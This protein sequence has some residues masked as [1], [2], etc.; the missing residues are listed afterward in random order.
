MSKEYDFFLENLNLLMRSALPV[1]EAI[2]TLKEEIK[3]RKMLRAIAIIENEI[4]GGSKMSTALGKSGLLSERYIALLRLGEETGELQKQLALVVEEQKKEKALQSK[5]RGAL[6]YP[7]M[8][9]LVTIVVGIFT[10]WY[11]FPKLTSVFASSGSELPFTTRVIISIGD[12]LTHWGVI[13]VP[14]GFISFGLAIY[15]LF[16]YKYTR[17]VGETLLLRFSVS[18][19]IVEGIELARFGYVVGSLLKAGITLPQ[20]LLSMKD[21]T[22]F[23]LY[24]RFYGNVLDNVTEGNSLY[25]SITKQSNYQMFIPS[26]LVRLISAGEKSGSLSETLLDI[27]EI[28][29]TKTENLAQNLSVLLE[30]VIIVVVGGIVAFLAIA[31]ISPIYGLTQ[32]IK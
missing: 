9:L 19:T 15:F 21:S 3:S 12:F 4:D 20:A 11:I 8:V 1:R 2:E 22:S 7:A 30:P 25:K 26:Y 27:G 24:R 16:I 5:I 10:M 29:E 23:V 17:Y 13:V 14:L 31:I 32:Q 18:R 28:Y 6:I